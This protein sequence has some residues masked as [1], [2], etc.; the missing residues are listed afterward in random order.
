MTDKDQYER[1]IERE[2]LARK[3]AERIMEDKS[4]ELYAANQRL[5]L[6]NTNL[7]I[8]VSKRTLEI[9]ES[10]AQL[11]LLFDEHPFPIIVYDLLEFKIIAINKTAL[12]KYNFS[13]TEFLKKRIIDLHPTHELKKLKDHLKS[14][15]KYDGVTQEW[16]HINA[17]GNAF[18][19]IVKGSS[20]VY[21]NQK[22]R[23]AVVEDITKKKKEEKERN[24]QNRK[25]QDLIESSSDIIYR[26]NTDGIFTYVNPT[27]I[28]L[29]G[30]TSEE[31]L[32]M[33]FTDLVAP[34]YKQRVINF[35]KFQ[36]ENNIE[37]TYIEFPIQIKDGSEI[38]L[39]QNVEPSGYNLNGV[40]IF[41]A[42]ARDITDRKRL[43]KALL[44]SE[45]KYRSIIEN[46]ELGLMEV[47]PEGV[48]IKAYPKFCKLSGYKAEELEGQKGALFLLD[49][50]GREFYK[51]QLADRSHGKSNV[52]E[53]QLI[54]KDGTK[55]WVL[56][57]GAPFYDEYNRVKGSFG[58]HLDI[59]ERKELESELKLA[60]EKAESSLKS[61]ELFLANI[62]HEIRTPLNAIIGITELMNLSTTEPESIKQLNHIGQAGK[63]LLSLINELLLLSKMD[64]Y[65][66]KLELKE[67]N[68]HSFLKQ[69]FELFEN[70]VHHKPINYVAEINLNESVYYWLDPIKLGQIIQNILSNAIK[71]TNQ[72]EVKLRANILNNSYDNDLIQF[73][74]NDTGIGIPPDNIDTIFNIFE[75]ASNN[76]S[77]TFRGTGLGLSIV[78]KL[79]ELMDGEINVVSENGTTSFEFFLNLKRSINSDTTDSFNTNK[80]S[81]KDF[82]GVKVLVAED[83]KVNQFLIEGYLKH[84]NI[85]FNIVNNGKEAINYLK[86]NKVDAVLMDMRMPVMNGLEATKIIRD[87]LEMNTLPILALTANAYNTHQKECK[88]AG[89]N[90]FLAKPFNIAQLQNILIKN[91]NF[92]SNERTPSLSS[93][94]EVNLPNSFQMKLDRIF[95]EDTEVRIIELEQAASIGNKQVLKDICHS[96]RPSLLHL[97]QTEIIEL[98]DHIEF[99]SSDIIGKTD[100]LIVKLKELINKMKSDLSDIPI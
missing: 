95:I 37:T 46:M 64:A 8:E 49:E 45:E 27:A 38:W 100:K 57:S 48:I 14:I 47:D 15:E 40:L 60:K 50:E 24:E 66:E 25:Y 97:K 69:N 7:E 31:L 55:R 70:Q 92:D 17:D 52:Y 42:T 59:T 18:D 6:L 5:S 90:D 67:T 20:I 72:G 85:E 78:K 94:D 29:S 11:N 28:K 77:G 43:E 80:E 74:I 58:I 10:E 36:L 54:K 65:K 83:N 56:V 12:V 13:R 98:T 99:R 35:Y 88:D 82:K 34:K 23:L 44:R 81:F 79:L 96:I 91:L 53:I 26:I 73:T 33:S 4:R 63:G 71:F 21:N 76:E 32:S 68:L 93:R 39:G 9:Q 51:K 84:L 3:E 2:R 89:M 87:D 19:V 41:N 16:T 86:N 30:Y 61:K 22:A 1:I 62:S 75:Q